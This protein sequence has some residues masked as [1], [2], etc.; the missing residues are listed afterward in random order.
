MMNLTQPKEPVLY[1]FYP[2]YDFYEESLNSQYIAHERYSVRE[3]NEI[4]HNL[5]KQWKITGKVK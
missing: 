5:V 2:Q 4:L 3:G 1:N